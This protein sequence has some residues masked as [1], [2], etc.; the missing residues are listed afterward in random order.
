MQLCCLTITLNHYR[1]CCLPQLALKCAD[2]G[3]LAAA[4]PVH[5]KWVS[6]LEAEFFAQGDEERARSMPISPLCDR[7]KEGITKSQVGFFEF[8]VSACCHRKFHQSAR[9]VCRA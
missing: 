3:H 2:L 7:T 9:H 1:V 8:V 5:L 4:L 6:A